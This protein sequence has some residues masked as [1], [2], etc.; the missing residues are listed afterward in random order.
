M[1]DYLRRTNQ[2]NTSNN[3]EMKQ[4][5]L[6]KHKG[7]PVFKSLLL[8]LPLKILSDKTLEYENVWMSGVSRKTQKQTRHT[9]LWNNVHAKIDSTYR[10]IYGWQRKGCNVLSLKNDMGFIQK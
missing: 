6:Q 2:M 10:I 7:Q 3:E 1:S 5:I 9:R 8:G 4:I